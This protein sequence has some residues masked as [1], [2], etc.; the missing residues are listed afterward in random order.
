MAGTKK[1]KNLPAGSGA[2]ALYS[3]LAIE[4]LHARGTVPI[5]VIL[6]DAAQDQLYIRFR[7]DLADVADEEALEVLDGIADA[8]MARVLTEGA[9]RLFNYLL[10]TLSGYVR[11]EEPRP[12]TAPANWKETVDRLFD[13]ND[14]RAAALAV[15]TGARAVTTVT[16]C[17]G[18]IHAT[19]MGMADYPGMA[20]PADYLRPEMWVAEVVY[21]PL[22]TELLKHARAV[23]CRTLNG[24]GMA[25]YQAAKAFELFTGSRPDED[26]MLDNL[27]R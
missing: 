5:G 11:I 21:F 27:T 24:G 7:D 6:L 22:E 3:V 18:L 14:A 8:I 26:R 23:G 15:K 10:D 2:E 25:V 16:R 9:T 4:Q 12:L 13:T 19:P 1:A 20:I 17:D